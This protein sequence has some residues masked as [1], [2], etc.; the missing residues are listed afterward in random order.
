MSILDK[1][2]KVGWLKLIEEF[3]NE[4]EKYFEKIE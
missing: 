4:N 2:I 3:N 1:N